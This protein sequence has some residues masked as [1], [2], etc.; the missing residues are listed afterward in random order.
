MT[1]NA[2]PV[3]ESLSPRLHALREGD[4]YVPATEA[5]GDPPGVY[6]ERLVA[7]PGGWW[8]RWDPYR[9]KLSAALLRGYDAPL[10][11][12]GERWLYLGAA[13][14]TTASHIADLV[15]PEGV[16]YAVEVS[17]RPFTRLLRLAERYPNLYPV[18]ADGRHPEGY[19]GLVP[20]VD[21]VY[22]DV[23]QADQA[24][25]ARDNASL[26]LRE[27]GMVVLVLKL[28]SIRRD[29]TPSEL[30]ARAMSELSPF[31][32][33]SAPVALE[34]FHRQHRLLAL[35]APTSRGP[36]PGR[37]SSP[38]RGPAGRRR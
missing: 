2:G 36:I 16:V 22:S 4:R 3:W 8:R 10:P 21:G 7:R 26:F 11:R 18:L 23:A 25:I 20:P 30:E 34:P 12:P 15:G 38:R 14:G 9:S 33:L 24:A 1:P 27:A 13:T 28:S 29:R 32:P 19:A 37:V 6:G 35:R 5:L 17:L 31:R